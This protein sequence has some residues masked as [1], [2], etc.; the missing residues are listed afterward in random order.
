MTNETGNKIVNITSE[1]KNL[2]LDKDYIDRNLNDKLNLLDKL[3]R[4]KL[5]TQK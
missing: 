4:D 3:S 2:E 5:M 1:Q